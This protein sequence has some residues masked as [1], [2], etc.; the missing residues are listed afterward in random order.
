MFTITQG[1]GADGSWIIQMTYI[2]CKM[3]IILKNKD[4]YSEGQGLDSP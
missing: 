1:L 3:Y 2:I 4:W